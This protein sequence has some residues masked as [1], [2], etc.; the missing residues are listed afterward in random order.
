MLFKEIPGNIAVKKQLINIVKNNRISHAYLFYGKS[1]NAKLALAFAFARYL[2]C[3]NKQEEDSCQKCQSCVKYKTLSHPD[4]HLTFPVLKIDGAKSVFSDKFVFRWRDF[5]L[6]NTYGSLNNWIDTF[7]KENKKGETGSIYKDEAILI[8]KKIELKNF[9]A[10]YRVFL[11]WMPEQMNIET[12]N[13]LL[14]ILE[15]PPTKTLFLLIS[16]E[17]RSLLP[18]ITSRL[19]TIKTHNFTVDDIIEFFTLKEKI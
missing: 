3:E 9:E 14:K 10:L 13:K 6:K 19:Q 8:H 2:N 17:P 4:L 12:S 16:E 18:T 15:E 11:I 5:I 7:G 1:G